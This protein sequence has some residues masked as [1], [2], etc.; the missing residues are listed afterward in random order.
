VIPTGSAIHLGGALYQ[1]ADAAAEGGF[2]TL[3]GERFARICNVD[4]LEPFLMNIVSDSDLWLFVGSNGPFTA[5]RGNADT[6][7]FPYQTVDK[8]LRH[9]DTSGAM[10]ILLV[11]RGGRTGLWEPWHDS[12]R[13]YDISRNLYKSVV[14]TSLVFEEYNHDLGL[15]LRTTLTTSDEF[16][17]VREVVIE[18]LDQDPVEVRYLDGWHQLI[19]PGV[20]QEIYARLSYLAAAYMRHERV[21]GT[22]MATFTLNAPISDRPEPSESLRAAAAWSVG[23]ANPVILLGERQ[24]AAF[25]RG[26]AV[27]PELEVRGEIGAYLAADSARLDGRARHSWFT[28][29]DTRLDHAALIDLRDRLASPSSLEA[30]LRT[31]VT[32]NRDG[33]RRRVASADGI[34]QGADEAATVAHFTRVL[35]NSMRGGTFD[36]S[37]EVPIA[38]AA[39]FLGHHNRAVLARHAAWLAT[40][41]TS[42]DAEALLGEAGR[43]GDPHLVRLL[44]TYLPIAF[45]RRHGDPSRPWNRF[46]IR[47]KDDLGRPLYGYEG[48]WRD[49]F[50]NWEAL[51]ES[52]PGFLEQF[53]AIFLDATTADGYNPY[54]ITRSGPDWEVPDPNDPWSHIGYWGDHQIVYLLRLLESRE[55]HA[56]G[57]LAASLADT[58]YAYAQVPYRIA[59]FEALIADPR[60]TITFDDPLHRS[61]MAR[62]TEIGADGKL[63]LDRAGEVRLVSLCEKLLVPLLVK[64]TNL[65]PGG[66]VWMNTQ[67]PE[68]ND[69]NNAL[70]G[71]GLSVVTVGAIRGY[72][73]FLEGLVAAD[74]EAPISASVVRLMEQVTA[75]LREA[76]A[77][78]DAA[79]RFDVLARLGRAGEEHRGDVYALR[80]GDPVPTPYR[81]IRD[82]VD[83]ARDVVDATLRANRRPDGLYQSYN[84]LNVVDRQARVEPLGL[85]LEGQVAVL[86]SGILGEQE[87]LDL[88]RAM[89]ASDLYSEEQQ[90]Y[91]LY[92]DREL[93]PFLARNTLAGPPPVADER[94]FVADRH[95]SWHFQADLSTLADVERALDAIGSDDATREEVLELWRT[96]FGHREFTGRS[97]T[98]FMFEGLG[99]VFW[100]MVSKYRMAVQ[101]AFGRTRDPEVSSGLARAYDEVV[102]GLGFRKTPAAFGAFPTDTHSHTPRHRGAQQP[103]MTGQAKEDILARL[104]ELGVGAAGGRLRFEPR[105]LHAAEFMDT[106]H[107]FEY[108]GLGGT[109]ETWE[110]PAR[111][112][113]FTFCQVP[114]CY[115]LGEAASIELERRDGGRERVAGHELGH[116]ASVAVFRRRGTYRRITVTIP[117]GNLLSGAPGSARRTD[118][119][120]GDE[121]D[122]QPDDPTDR[123]KTGK[124]GLQTQGGM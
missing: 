55:R 52:Y 28:V 4:R 43:R 96:T 70:A 44:R 91:L 74:G 56:P 11:T 38:D 123:A 104:G 83:A 9:P 86:E 76:R 60:E 41:P 18:N 120:Q 71:W 36:G 77:P 10:T 81:T 50:Q 62:V 14:G 37:Y 25:R 45:S 6:A 82:L 78:L 58:A 51:A 114:V 87:A 16:G 75:A 111:T 65:V 57:S 54:R 66:G 89:W 64:L 84:L 115:R 26:A 21:P 106:P 2:S 29:C 112:M 68:W 17:L 48:N 3:D 34:Q 105:L 98:F 72:L 19:A 95:G 102:A 73:R 53:I 122:H 63:V 32:A 97:G 118:A 20:S 61:L 117:S 59:G 124:S 103:G 119:E 69:G 88:V 121:R 101:A 92:P 79:G 49:I 107:R 27:K 108:L 35:Y 113:A 39:E 110:L 80:L 8:I 67:R 42:L 94:L 1:P 24:V 33:I 116:D 46:T 15:V 30:A 93:V 109:T 13:V 22:S 47:L 40:L 23:H 12:G 90:T 7:L 100:H 5:G 85:M 99:S 31:A